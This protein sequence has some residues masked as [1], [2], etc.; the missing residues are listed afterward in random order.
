MQVLVQYQ[1]HLLHHRLLVSKE[2]LSLL[3]DYYNSIYHL[4]TLTEMT[5]AFFAAPSKVPAAMPAAIVPCPCKSLSLLD[6]LAVVTP[7]IARPVRSK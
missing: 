1:K 2:C 5:V 4:I 6:F 7:H 3:V